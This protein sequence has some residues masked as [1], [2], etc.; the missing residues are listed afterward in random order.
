MQSEE[1][2]THA[3][4]SS[5][6]AF[7]LWLITLGSGLIA[8]LVAS[9]G[10]E[11]TYQALHK[12]PQYPASIDSLG[13]SERAI[14]RAVVRYQTKS[15]VETNKATAA[16][17]L[18]G[19]TLGLV[20]GV[21]GGL[22]GRARRPRLAGAAVGGVLGGVV[23]AGLSMLLVPR[24]FQLSD[25]QTALP[26]IFLTHA[27]IFAGI[28]AA[29]GAAFGWEWG[30]RKIIVRSALGAIAGAVIATLVIEVINVAAFGISRIFEPVPSISLARFVVNLGVAL[31]VTLG[32]VLA[33]RKLRA[34]QS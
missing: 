23:G 30:D 16:Y 10:G 22:A 18:L 33:G 2:Q 4:G 13:S 12:E 20:L 17:G 25:A 32:A 26:L 15:V 29:L 1:P 8:G 11:L 6:R 19:V 5:S 27:A 7:P 24:F 31:G 9:F 14:A 3:G 21:A 28:G 34:R